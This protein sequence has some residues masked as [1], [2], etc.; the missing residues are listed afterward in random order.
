MIQDFLFP[1]CRARMRASRTAPALG[2]ADPSYDMRSLQEPGRLDAAN[3]G[4]VDRMQA[5]DPLVTRERPHAC[6]KE[7]RRLNPRGEL[8]TADN[9]AERLPMRNSVAWL[10]RTAPLPSMRTIGTRSPTSRSGWC[11][12]A[13][14]ESE[15]CLVRAPFVDVTTAEQPTASA[16]RPGRRWSGLPKPAGPVTPRL[17]PTCNLGRAPWGKGAGACPY[18]R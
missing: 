15:D 4:I 7:R 2:G 17:R 10:G 3:S 18:R 9:I 12:A 14:A 5:G 16:I 11:I 6:W 13:H 8:Y 1:G